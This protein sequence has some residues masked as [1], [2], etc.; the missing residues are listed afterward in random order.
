M[1]P[2]K[3]HIREIKSIKH[4]YV[5]K[6]GFDL[7]TEI[8]QLPTAIAR[9]PYLPRPAQIKN[10]LDAIVELTEALK[11]TLLNTSAHTKIM[12]NHIPDFLIDIVEYKDIRHLKK[13]WNVSALENDLNTLS[14]A[15]MYALPQVPEDHGGP[16]KRSIPK[17]VIFKL[18]SIYERGTDTKPK[19]GWSENSDEYIGKFYQFLIEITPLL[20]DLNIKMVSEETVGRYNVDSLKHIEPQKNI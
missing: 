11:K 20:N 10:E 12:L 19:C 18:A 16:Q 15:C 8:Y 1:K 9:A 6:E 17:Y 5:F 14:Q 7:L 3:K 13:N 4:T 2:L